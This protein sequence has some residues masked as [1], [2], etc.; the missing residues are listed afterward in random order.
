MPPTDNLYKFIAISGILIYLFSGN[1]AVSQF[2]KY[3]EVK[4]A[5]LRDSITFSNKI[6]Q[7]SIQMIQYAFTLSKEDSTSIEVAKKK[8]ETNFTD[9]SQEIHF[10]F[11]KLKADIVMNKDLMLN[12]Q[13]GVNDKWHYTK[14]TTGLFVIALFFGSFLSL[15]GFYKWHIRIQIPYEKNMGLEVKKTKFWFYHIISILFIA[16]NFLMIAYLGKK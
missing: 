1:L 4:N 15:L 14:K 8:L 2:V 9:Q 12:A 3:R 16:S 11:Q 6:K 10:N 7:D 13:E 5:Y